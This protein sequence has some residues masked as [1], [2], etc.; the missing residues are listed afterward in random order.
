MIVA[1]AAL[2]TQNYTSSQMLQ[3][4]QE[5]EYNAILD[6][7]R[8]DFE[9]IMHKRF[10][11]YNRMIAKLTQSRRPLIAF[12]SVI[13]N[14]VGKQELHVHLPDGTPLLMDAS[15][16]LAI[17]NTPGLYQRVKG[18]ITGKRDRKDDRPAIE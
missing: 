13:A 1:F 7:E 10:E 8:A 9:N 2:S 14:P 4:F 6:A 12:N 11:N 18:L 3:E 16:R 5:R 17:T 15:G